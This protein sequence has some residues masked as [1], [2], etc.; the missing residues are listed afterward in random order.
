MTQ[1][2][3]ILQELNEL[4]SGLAKIPATNVYSVPQGYF[5]KLLPQVM[6]RIKAMETTDAA[7]ELAHLSPMLSTLKKD[8]PFSVP[9]GYFENLSIPSRIEAPAAK[10]VSFTQR[11][12]YRYAA[13]AVVTGLVVLAGF[14]FIA[15]NSSNKAPLAQFTKD[16]K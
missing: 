11:K 8:M 9:Q 10:V 15:K 1:R 6:A 3:T 14:L 12:W 2:E 4:Q 5:D 16:V 7:E 13:A